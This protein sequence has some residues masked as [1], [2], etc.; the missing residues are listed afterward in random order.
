MMILPFAFVNI[1]DIIFL[2]TSVIDV[3]AIN[4]IALSVIIS[5]LT[6]IKNTTRSITMYFTIDHNTNLE[7][8]KYHKAPITIKI[9]KENFISELLLALELESANAILKMGIF[10]SLLTGALIGMIASFNLNNFI[11][12]IAV[13]SVRIATNQSLKFN[14]RNRYRH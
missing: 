13:L 4:I 5:I 1:H 9:V 7:H 8:K 12:S 6:L 14:T 3:F 11:F 10:A 2:I